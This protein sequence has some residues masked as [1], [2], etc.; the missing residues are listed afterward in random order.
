MEKLAN[1]LDRIVVPRKGGGQ[2]K[3]INKSGYAV[4]STKHYML[5]K[6][7]TLHLKRLGILCDGYLLI[8]ANH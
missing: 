3:R 7:R 4:N 2:D 6:R 8:L 1:S 5:C